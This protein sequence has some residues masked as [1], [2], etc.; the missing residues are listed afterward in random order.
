MY[1]KDWVNKRIYAII[2]HFGQDFF[3]GKKILDIG[4][5]HGMIARAFADLG[6][7]VTCVDIRKSHLDA[8][9]SS[10]PSIKCV[11]ADLD[12]EWPF[13]NDFYDIILHLGTLN[14]LMYAEKHLSFICQSANY[15]VLDC[16]VCDSTDASKYILVKENRNNTLQAYNGIGCKPSPAFV[17]R[18]LS[19]AGMIFERLEDD[20]CNSGRYVYDWTSKNSGSVTAGL[21][22]LWFIK[23]HALKNVAPK[24]VAV[25]Q[26]P[27]SAVRKNKLLAPVLPP[28]PVNTP[29]WHPPIYEN[30][31]RKADSVTDRSIHFGLVT[32]DV[33]KTTEVFTT[34]GI[35]L[36]LTNSSRQWIKKIAPF[37]P[38]L[39]VNRLAH[40]M[41]GFQKTDREPNITMC[42]IHNLYPCDRVW[43]EEWSGIPL[44]DKIVTAL[45][46]YKEILTP[47]LLNAQAIIEKIPNANV[48]R[49]ARPWPLLSVNADQSGHFLYFE[50]T[51]SLTKILVDSW[52][53]QYG[54]LVVVGTRMKLP[55]AVTFISD[56]DDYKEINKLMYGAQAIIDLSENDYYYSGVVNAAKAMGLPVITNNTFGLLEGQVTIPYD[57][58]TKAF[59]I[60]KAI[61]AFKALPKQQTNFN[62]KHNEEVNNAVKLLIG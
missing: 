3:E 2:N 36:P 17:E 9:H 41:R 60:E 24:V 8:V 1:D 23:R 5:G 54:K 56:C 25:K 7:R 50:K 59:G 30:L 47:S 46:S 49:V 38:N 29:T 16:Q 51:E 10:N 48:K 26:E 37:F 57:N 13:H 21:S 4:T 43:I 35:F 27:V 28:R 34:N 19:N 18:V 32:A 33:F 61:L 31:P 44:N 6:A 52:S 58:K 14:H 20:T 40:T 15:I 11:K 55:E 45:K 42:E 62:S 39:K 22:K 53:S 12:Q